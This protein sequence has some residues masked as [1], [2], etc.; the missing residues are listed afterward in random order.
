MLTGCVFGAGSAAGCA[1]S[2]VGATG[3]VSL[4]PGIGSL[5][6]IT[7]DSPIY[8]PRTYALSS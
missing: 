6:G 1:V 7:S 8:Q 5:S 4:G 3:G 2:G